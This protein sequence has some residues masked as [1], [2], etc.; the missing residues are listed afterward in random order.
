MAKLT[1]IIPAYNEEKNILT[2]LASLNEQYDLDNKKINKD[3]YQIVVVNNQST[4]KTKEVVNDFI[5]VENNP[6]CFLIESEI[7]GVVPTRITGYNYVINNY[8]ITTDLLASGDADINFHKNWVYHTLLNF[9]KHNPDV[10]SCAGCFPDSFW[11]KVP[12]LVKKYLSEI[13]T[14]FFNIDT[15]KRL[16]LVGKNFKFTNQIFNDF[17]RPVTDGCF[18]ITKK[19]YLKAGGYKREFETN[20]PTKEIYGEGWRLVFV[21]EKMN[22]NIYYQKD[23]YYESSPRR[24]LEEPEKFLGAISYKGQ[25]DDLRNTTSDLYE[26]LDNYAKNVDLTSIK[27]YV[28]NYYV[29]LRCITQPELIDKN[30]IY[31]GNSSLGLRQDILSWWRKNGKEFKGG[32]LISLSEDL[33]NKYFEDIYS[34]IPLQMI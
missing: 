27:K 26:R 15:I 22:G 12:T 31:F 7:K 25:M 20:D 33:G 23:A 2:C 24:I 11:I 1:I 8:E 17:G 3:L 9:E 14:I 10:I 34:A 18:A 21:I 5:R 4:D 19:A 28:I 6:K 16:D 13:G 29:I 32:D 30:Q